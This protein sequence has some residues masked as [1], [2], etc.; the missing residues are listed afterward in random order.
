[1]QILINWKINVLSLRKSNVLNKDSQVIGKMNK[2][3]IYSKNNDYNC[4]TIYSIASKIN[5]LHTV[6]FEI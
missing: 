4:F 6:L 1:M 5:Q 3:I 2:I